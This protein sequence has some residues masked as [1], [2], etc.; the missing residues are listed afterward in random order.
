[1]RLIDK[2]CDPRSLKSPSAEETGGCWCH[3]HAYVSSSNVD[4]LRI[5]MRSVQGSAAHLLPE[6][7]L[8]LLYQ[9]VKVVVVTLVVVVVVVTASC[10]THRPC[11]R[12]RRHHPLRGMCSFETALASGYLFLCLCHAVRARG[13]LA[14]DVGGV[15]GDFAQIKAG[16][17]ARRRRMRGAVREQDDEQRAYKQESKRGGI[18]EGLRPGFVEG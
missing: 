3:S 8:V 9:V 14:R 17:C 1:M 7:P 10:L 13:A 4:R 2:V 12:S 11:L 15:G 6:A 5:V 16:S 18:Q